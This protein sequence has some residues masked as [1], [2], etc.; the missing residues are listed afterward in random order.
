MLN[1]ASIAEA[2]AL[3]GDLGLLRAIKR[4]DAKSAVQNIDWKSKYW[5]KCCLPM[6][7]W[8]ISS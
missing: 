4:V 1:G 7:G 3:G 5:I 6:K 2:L 8:E